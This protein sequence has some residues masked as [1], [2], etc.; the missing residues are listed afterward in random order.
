MALTVTIRN[1]GT[2]PALGVR[3]TLQSIAGAR[4]VAV[5]SPHGPC[6]A[7][8]GLPACDLGVLA[9]GEETTVYVIGTPRK[10]GAIQGRLVATTS[11]ADVFDSTTRSTS[12]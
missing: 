12:S 6:N 9:A 10:P 8:S 4:D 11:S 7:S 5:S 1:D 3:T 2:E